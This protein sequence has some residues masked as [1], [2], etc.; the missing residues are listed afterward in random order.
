MNVNLDDDV[1]LLNTQKKLI[2]AE[3]ENLEHLKNRKAKK[4]ALKTLTRDLSIFDSDKNMLSKYDPY[5]A[6]GG[7]GVLGA[8]VAA[9]HG[10]NRDL[11]LKVEQASSALQRTLMQEKIIAQQLG[12]LAPII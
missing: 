6:L 4:R 3:I 8:G 1:Q 12:Q 9:A 11:H 10:K 7:L 2:N 5:F